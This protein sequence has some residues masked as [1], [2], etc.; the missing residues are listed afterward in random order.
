M[1]KTLKMVKKIVGYNVKVGVTLK[2][3]REETNRVVVGETLKISEQ[4]GRLTQ[5]ETGLGSQ[6]PNRFCKRVKAHRIKS[7]PKNNKK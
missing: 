4:I 1:G 7:I 3:A 2:I 6:N 5:R